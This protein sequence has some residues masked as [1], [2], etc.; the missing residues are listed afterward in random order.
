MWPKAKIDNRRQISNRIGSQKPR[1]L[2][3]L[4]IFWIFD[5]QFEPARVRLVFKH[6]KHRVLYAFEPFLELRFQY[7]PACLNLV[8]KHRILCFLAFLGPEEMQREEEVDMCQMK[9]LFV[10]LQNFSFQCK[11]LSFRG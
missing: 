6:R 4:R 2:H 1:K 3:A 7:E 11:W 5:F 9:I 10:F 8:L